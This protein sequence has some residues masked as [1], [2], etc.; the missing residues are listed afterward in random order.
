MDHVLQLY[1]EESCLLDALAEFVAAGLR[2]EEGVLFVG[3]TPRWDLLI[4]RLQKSG[5]DARAYA[6]RGQLKLY[7][8]HV[9][10]SSCTNGAGVD[11]SKLGRLLGSALELGRMRYERVR[12]F[13]ELTDTR[14]RDGD[15]AGAAA[16]ERVW[17]PLLGVHDFTLL[18][19]CPIDS[20]EEDTYDGTLQALCG[21]HTHVS[22]ARDEAGFED[23]VNGAVAE[24]LDSQLVRMLEALS[25]AYRPSAQMPPGQAMLFWLTDHMPRTAEKVMRRARARWSEH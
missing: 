6:A 20:L 19:A 24:V 23:A 5:V 18:C 1:Q 10:L 21:A 8:V 15:R 2:L 25:A 12:M 14:W 16:L 4:D 11:R 3:T 17:K 7:G 22:P 13:S 9:L